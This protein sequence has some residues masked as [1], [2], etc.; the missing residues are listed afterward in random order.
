MTKDEYLKKFAR[1]NEVS[2][3]FG[4][5]IVGIGNKIIQLMKKEDITYEQAYASLQ[6]A[7][8]KLKFESNFLKI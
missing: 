4:K 7:Y 8:N 2:D 3:L 5:E 1:Q 6:Y